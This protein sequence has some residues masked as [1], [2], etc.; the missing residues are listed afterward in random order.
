[1]PTSYSRWGRALASA[2]SAALRSRSARY[3]STDSAA[4]A[5]IPS[6]YITESRRRQPSADPGSMPPVR[7]ASIPASQR[8]AISAGTSTPKY[9]P[10]AS[11]SYSSKSSC[12]TVYAYGLASRPKNASITRCAVRRGILV[13][14]ISW[15]V[16]DFCLGL[17]IPLTLGLRVGDCLLD[18]CPHLLDR[19]A[20]V[21]DE[22]LPHDD[23][24][25]ASPVV[26]RGQ[27]ADDF[28]GPRRVVHRRLLGGEFRRAHTTTLL[29]HGFLSTGNRRGIDDSDAAR[30]ARL[31]RVDQ[32]PEATER[33]EPV[34]GVLRVNRRR[35]G[36]QRA[37]DGL[38]VRPADERVA[39]VVR[40][41]VVVPH[42][43]SSR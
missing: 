23:P 34:P 10:A 35:L 26:E 31:Q 8:R 39:R 29:T 37:H 9:S 4:P 15:V 25:R 42:A 21:V 28:R 17:G 32:L 38:A 13:I 6:G 19:D 11:L 2:A 16:V 40:G 20:R 7:H 18:D 14:V 1:M 5:G 41:A 3:A 36:R 27:S 22:C 30:L 24:E 12:V 33:D 43:P